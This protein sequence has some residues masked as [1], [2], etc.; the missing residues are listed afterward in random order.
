MAV[1]RN[2]YMSFTERIDFQELHANTRMRALHFSIKDTVDKDTHFTLHAVVV[3]SG[4][5]QTGHYF[6]HIRD[7]RNPTGWLTID[8]EKVYPVHADTVFKH[9]TG[10]VFSDGRVSNV[11]AYLLFY[12]RTTRIEQV[13]NGIEPM[14]ESVPL[15]SSSLNSSSSSTSNSSSSLVSNSSLLLKI[16]LFEFLSIDF[17]FKSFLWFHLFTQLFFKLNVFIKL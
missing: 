8:N 6:L 15:P 16:K 7:L 4:S 17:K 5:A 1:R 10:G 2:D 12:I 13:V 14:P 11:N 3:H 9:I